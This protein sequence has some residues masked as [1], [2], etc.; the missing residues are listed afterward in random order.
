MF[1]SIAPSKL[2][3][4]KIAPYLI[5]PFKDFPSRVIANPKRLSSSF[6][7][8][9]F[10]APAAGSLRTQRSEASFIFVAAK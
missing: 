3:R 5:A 8:G 2:D 4:L 10:G 7:R 1:R 6:S 9:K